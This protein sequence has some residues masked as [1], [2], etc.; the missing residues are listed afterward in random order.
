M[1]ASTEAGG[2]RVCINRNGYHC[3]DGLDG[4]INV[5]IKLFLCYVLVG[6]KESE[7]REKSLN[8]SE[9]Q[10]DL[11]D[12]ETWGDQK[13]WLNFICLIYNGLIFFGCLSFQVTL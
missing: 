4:K 13:H 10:R 5:M 2:I 7:E 3:M 6:R 1:Q 9:W 12:D 8:W 11:D